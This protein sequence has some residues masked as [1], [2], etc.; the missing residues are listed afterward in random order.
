MNQANSHLSMFQT[1]P[2]QGFIHRQSHTQALSIG[3]I[4]VTET[5]SCSLQV[6]YRSEPK[7][8]VGQLTGICRALT[9]LTLGSL[10]LS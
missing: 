8:G 9:W 2:A 6:Q 10:I 5:D 3:L 4:H 1:Q 7:V